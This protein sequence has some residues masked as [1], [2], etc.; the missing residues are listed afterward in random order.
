MSCARAFRE[1][2]PT[3]C[4]RPEASPDGDAGADGARARSTAC[5]KY[6]KPRPH[7]LSNGEYCL[8]RR[9]E[10]NVMKH[11]WIRGRGR[12]VRWTVGTLLL[13]AAAATHT[14]FATAED[15]TLTLRG[16]LP[17]QCS[18]RTDYRSG[19]RDALAEL[20][21]GVAIPDRPNRRA[22]LRSRCRGAGAWRGISA[23]C[24][25]VYNVLTSH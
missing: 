8:Q 4:A 18:C 22:V 25:H 23:R 14:L 6:P 21:A 3:L 9:T 7:G 2:V 1:F 20:S 17:G 19:F 11:V 16:F 15:S 5:L 10:E 13:S 12:Q 24:V